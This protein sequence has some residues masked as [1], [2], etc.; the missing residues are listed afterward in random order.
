M[1]EHSA[2]ELDPYAYAIVGKAL[3]DYFEEIE[4]AKQL[5]EEAKKLERRT[6]WI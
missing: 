1:T 2:F 6:A 4:K 5:L 3:R